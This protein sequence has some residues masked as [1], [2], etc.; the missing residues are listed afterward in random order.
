MGCSASQGA[1]RP[2][3]AVPPQGPGPANFSL[4]GIAV[5]VQVHLVMLDRLPR[6]LHQNV[7]VALFFPIV[8]DLGV[9]SLQP[10]QEVATGELIALVGVADL[11]PAAT[12]QCYLQS[13]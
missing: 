13:R 4:P 6:P 3:M 12:F 10:G 8:A 9:L 7:I 5:G 2:Y 11:W 1:D